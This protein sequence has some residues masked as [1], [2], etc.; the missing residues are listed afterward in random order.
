MFGDTSTLYRY[1]ALIMLILMVSTT[2]V[3]TEVVTETIKEYS[4]TITGNYTI[5]EVDMEIVN[6]TVYNYIYIAL[7]TLD[8]GAGH[9]YGVIILYDPDMDKPVLYLMAGSGNSWHSIMNVS[10]GVEIN[11]SILIDHVNKTIYYNIGGKAGAINKSL[12]IKPKGASII[13]NTLGK[14]YPPPSIHLKKIV[15]L[16][17]NNSHAIDYFKSNELDMLEN[18][19]IVRMN[20]TE[21][22]IKPAPTTTTSSPI[23]STTIGYIQT[24]QQPLTPSTIVLIVSIIAVTITIIALLLTHRKRSP[25]P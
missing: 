1:V 12:I 2:I 14:E 23:G 11:F 13:L 25:G 15:V 3:S 20:K 5:L 16:E 24:H 21:I 10:I 7:D 18:I 22:S 9:S 8:Q 6:M 19:S 17:T 4:L